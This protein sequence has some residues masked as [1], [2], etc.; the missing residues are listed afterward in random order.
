MR[1]IEIDDFEVEGE[2]FTLTADV[3]R[4]YVNDMWLE[5]LHGDISVPRD[6]EDIAMEWIAEA[7]YE[8]GY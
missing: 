6:M 7:Y 3:D 5:G 2:L 8:G 4:G 1:T